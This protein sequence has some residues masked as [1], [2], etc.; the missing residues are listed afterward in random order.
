MGLGSLILDPPISDLCEVEQVG[1]I[2]A[3]KHKRQ[4]EGIAVSLGVSLHLHGHQLSKVSERHR[5]FPRCLMLY[6]ELAERVISS[7]LVVNGMV[8]YSPEVAEVDASGVLAR[9]GKSHPGIELLQP[10]CRDVLEGQRLGI[11]EECFDT[12][13]GRFV[14]RP[15][16]R[17]RTGRIPP[18]RRKQ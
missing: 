14:Q 8:E 6:L 9:R 16:L 10:P 18:Y 4:H 13:C 12:S 15:R 3:D 17:C 5:S 2:D 1:H 7:I 11:L